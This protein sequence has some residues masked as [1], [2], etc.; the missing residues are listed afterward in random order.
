M[1]QVHTR[2][3]SEHVKLLADIHIAMYTVS[4]HSTMGQDSWQH[5]HIQ[6]AHISQLLAHIA[7]K[8]KP[9]MLQISRTNSWRA[10]GSFVD[11]SCRYI[12][13]YLATLETPLHLIQNQE[14]SINTIINGRDIVSESYQILHLSLYDG[15]DWILS[16]ISIIVWWS[17]LQCSGK[18]WRYILH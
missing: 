5:F 16:K 6:I 7:C 3:M 13:K 15:W 2:H 9:Y 10:H 8:V 4:M 11:T 1:F 12:T 14:M 18:V 17:K